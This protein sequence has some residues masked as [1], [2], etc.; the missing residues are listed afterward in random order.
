MLGQMGASAWYDERVMQACH[1]LLEHALLP[2]GQ[3]SY[4]KAPSGTFDCLQGNLLWSLRVKGIDDPRLQA[5]YE[6]TA[7]TITGE[8]LAPSSDRKAEQRYYAYKC[9]PL[10]ACGANYGQ[11]CAWGAVK[12]MLALG[13]CPAEWRSPLVERAI[14]E[15]VN[16]LLDNRPAEAAYPNGENPKPSGNWWKFGFPIFYVSDILQI[17][18]AMAGFSHMGCRSKSECRNSPNR[19]N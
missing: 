14:G 15:G 8:G 5:A 12:V 3:M 7:R 1:Y 17:A 6:W 9:G 10:F 4:N 2:G 11:P 13:L 19:W 16:F 18:E